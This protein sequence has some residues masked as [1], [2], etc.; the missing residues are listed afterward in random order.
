MAAHAG[1]FTPGSSGLK[2]S[3]FPKSG[4]GGYDVSHYD[5]KLRFTPKTHHLSAT[6]TITA[7]ATQNL[8]RFN[9]D[10]SG[11]TISR[12]EVNGSRAKYARH[13]QEL[14]VTPKKGLVSGTQFTVVVA[15]AGRPH[16]INDKV[17]GLEGW[18]NTK[19][20]AT[21]VSEPDGAR[22]W[23]PSN[24]TPQDKATFTFTVSAPT[25]VTVLANGEPVNPGI[26]GVRHGWSTVKWE[27]RQPM[28]TYL[29]TV[30]IG[31]FHVTEGRAL[32]MLNLTAYDPS[33]AKKSR[34]LH[35]VTRKAIEW[36]SKVFG[37]YPFASVGGIA[38]KLDVGYALETQTR[39]IYDSGPTNDLE[40]VHELAHQWFG[41]S[42]GLRAW[43][44]I[45]LNEGFATYAEWLYEEQHGGPSAKSTFAKLYKSPKSFWRLKTGDPGYAH[46][47]DY[48][49][50]YQRG[51]MT[52]QALRAKIGDTVFFDLLKEWTDAN[53][54][55]TVITRDFIDL[56]EQKS[57][58]DLDP[59][60]DAWLY[61]A[62]KPA[63]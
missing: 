7:R 5:L 31:K 11:P 57:G 53:R 25:G 29:A 3:Y 12:V 21:A 47:F 27:M 14:V 24:D 40:I 35:T 17:L 13:G 30:A 1:D 41:D 62:K 59:F 42:V 4:N 56:A 51:A 8:S 60:F 46:M 20:G 28:A 55:G 23:L 38:D 36:E 54:H 22:S 43:K 9:L 2:D 44:D 32:G 50:V 33:L 34:H 18:V 19:D 15:Y 63:I 16:A 10:F 52:L 45:W 48:A 61:T 49:P 26:V 39:P 6:V 37:Q 58:Q